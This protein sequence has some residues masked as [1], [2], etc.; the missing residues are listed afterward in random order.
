MDGRETEG[1]EVID[2]K[3]MK[4]ILQ[5][6]KPGERL[7]LRERYIKDADLSGY[8]L[9]NI[10]FAGSTL[11][12]VDLTGADMDGDNVHKVWFKDCPMHAVKLTNC[13]A[14]EATFRWIDLTDGDISGTNIF[15]SLLEYAKLD[16]LKY[17]DRTQ[18]YKLRCPETGP[19]IG[20]KCCTEWRV[21]Q[22]LIPADAKRVSAT[23]NTC[24]CSKAKVLSIKSI[25]ETVS[26]TWAQSTVDSDFYYEVGKWAIPSGFQEDR[27]MDSSP[28]I[29]FFMERQECVDY[30]T[31]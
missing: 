4:K 11:E 23:A 16:G 19:F 6:R 31:R 28:G 8:D 25:D 3:K 13:D 10:D 9:R 12:K 20:W 7:D 2:D 22:L 5:S 14:T 21:V 17:D 26:Y 18:Y 29:H 1:I 27:W 24:R 15:C 30:Q